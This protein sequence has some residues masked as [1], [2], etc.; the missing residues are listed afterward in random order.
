MS[1]ENITMNEGSSEQ[2]N[3]EE[4][5]KQTKEEVERLRKLREELLRDLK[6]VKT[7]RDTLRQQAM[8]EE[9]QIKAEIERLR[10]IEKEKQELEKQHLAA[11][12]ILT[13]GRDLHDLFHPL[14]KG[15]TEEEILASIEE[16]KAKQ[17]ELLASANP[18]PQATPTPPPPPSPTGTATPIAMPDD[19]TIRNMS[20]EEFAEFSRRVKSM[21]FPNASS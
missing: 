18:A 15:E 6:K 11:R 5:Y 12:L 4:L 2:P 14:V 19:E 13:H 1:E 3:L 9:E 8:T 7:E 20:S 21:L 10:Q 16:L 17:A